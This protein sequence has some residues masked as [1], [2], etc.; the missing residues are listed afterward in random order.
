MT[1]ALRPYQRKLADAVTADLRRG[2]EEVLL[3]ACPGFGKTEVALE[4]IA[5]LI[6][7]RR[8][9]GALVL[10]HGT[11][12]LRS[13]FQERLQARRPDLVSRVQVALPHAWR[14]LTGHWDLVVIDEAHEFYEA[15]EGGMVARVLKQVG[16][17]QRLLLTGTPARFIRRGLEPHA[18][19][20]Q[21]LFD[22][23]GGRWVSDI[24][25]DLALSSYA[26]GEKDWNQAGEVQ[27]GIRYRQRQT[28]K[29]LADLLA[30]LG[31][32]LQLGKAPTLV[33]CK[34]IEM[35][36]QVASF[37]ARRGLDHLVSH[38]G[39]GDDSANVAAFKAGRAPLLVI[40]RRGQLGFDYPGLQNFIDLTGS[41]NPDRIFQMMC[42]L[43][44][45]GPQPKTFVKVMP[46]A[47]SGEHLRLFMTGVCAL[48]HRELYTS[49]TGGS[50]YRLRV[51][52]PVGRG[53]EGRAGDGGGE[54]KRPVFDREMML[55][56][57]AFEEVRDTSG[58]LATATLGR[59]LGKRSGV[60]IT[61]EGCTK[62]AYEW[63]RDVGFKRGTVWT[64][65]RAG[66]RGRALLAQPQSSDPYKLAILAFFKRHKRWPSRGTAAQ[67][68]E[69]KLAERLTRYTRRWSTS[70]DDRFRAEVTA[71]G[72]RPKGLFIHHLVQING[73]AQSLLNWSRTSGVDL[74]TLSARY[75]RGERGRKL[76]R[77]T[78]LRRHVTIGGRTR[79]TEEWAALA[80]VTRGAFQ[81]RL[82]L[83][84][85]GNA[86]LS[87]QGTYRRGRQG[88]VGQGIS[89][90][91][92][93]LSLAGWAKIS[94]LP[95]STIWNRL[96]RGV[97][98]AGLL[99]PRY[100]VTLPASPAAPGSP[101]GSTSP[102]TR[103]GP[104]RPRSPASRSP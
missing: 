82:T 87:P 79:P 85:R 72:W 70:F 101:A 2:T 49:W 5:R 27:K 63:D 74:T 62:R 1:F 58:R 64:R 54:R 37:F 26:I 25:V 15:G 16:A 53:G 99:A 75:N 48:K 94:G 98:G 100:R 8:I 95:T 22:V 71:M 35:A 45:P 84:W 69:R 76:L 65:Y 83:G 39:V 102:P 4:I 55:F 6:R 66:T 18:F 50:F 51:P 20:L 7:S 97:E 46:K 56:G 52:V 36:D 43:C 41:R 68:H 47:F 10:A 28:D 9:K 57:D 14:Q 61:I 34:N 86:L 23:E 80:G 29:T 78:D 11:S 24:R 96:K 67:Q 12:V 44:R 91:G 92:R 38:Q 93:T 13:N 77:S 17:R 33:A 104:A 89:I 103:R 81:A 90:S 40:V 59:S 30:G 42:R 3:A 31:A 73:K 60:E 32:R 88:L 19:A 21:E